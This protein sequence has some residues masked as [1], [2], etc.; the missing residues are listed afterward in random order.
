MF[1]VA[2]DPRD[3]LF[4][5]MLALSGAFHAAAFLIMAVWAAFSKPL[6]SIAPVTVVDLVGGGPVAAPPVA[7]VR[8]RDDRRE[9][10]P[11]ARRKESRKS[12][13]A[14]RLAAK[15]AAPPRSA[16]RPDG[17]AP[18]DTRPLSERIRKLRE[19]K[20]AEARA[21]E[22]VAEVRRER[23]IRQAVR[24]IKD[25]VARRVD[26]TAARPLPRGATAPAVPAG[27]VGGS[28]A[29]ATRLPPEHLA[30]FRALDEKVRENWTVPE[31]AVRDRRKLFVQVIVAIEKD[32]R[33]SE[34]RMEKASGN[35]YFDDSVRRAIQKASPLP[36][37]PEQLRGGENRYEVGFRFYGSEEAS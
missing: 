7:S 29:S 18:P 37:P 20:A 4:R 8:A 27:L 36:V 30:Y 24:G 25:Q 33:V 1:P 12:R 6:L 35:V 32:G 34:V 14:D 13:K 5:R 17:M 23:E 15:K 22:A 11:A 10:A 19:E 26:L 3:D 21:G 2:W 16:V 31:L 28:G 9:P